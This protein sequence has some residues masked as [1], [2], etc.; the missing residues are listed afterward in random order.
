MAVGH[1][2]LTR[3]SGTPRSGNLVGRNVATFIETPE[4][5][6]GRP[7]N[8]LTLQQA[9]ALL[10]VTEGTP[11]AAV[12]RSVRSHGDTKTEKSRRTLRLPANGGGRAP[13]PE[14]TARKGT[15]AAG[16]Q[17]NDHDLVLLTT[18]GLCVG[19]G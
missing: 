14:G 6:S 7:S 19:R 2:T 13:S 16:G 9:S 1:N 8:S 10:A 12:W 5:Q 4:G 11:S 3:P 17:W 15:L 18:D